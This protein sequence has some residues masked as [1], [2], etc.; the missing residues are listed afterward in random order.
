MIACKSGVIILV[1]LFENFYS[2]RAN[3]NIGYVVAPWFGCVSSVGGGG[4]SGSGNW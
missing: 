3:K 4:G 1:A 2:Q